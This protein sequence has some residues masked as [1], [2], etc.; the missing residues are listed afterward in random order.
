MGFTELLETLGDHRA[1]DVEVGSDAFCFAASIL[2]LGDSTPA[3]IALRNQSCDASFF[4][5]RTRKDKTTATSKTED[6]DVL[7]E[8][9][10]RFLS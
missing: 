3:Q 10:W 6:G 8:V 9:S 5:R 7:V 1:S 2:A 4:R